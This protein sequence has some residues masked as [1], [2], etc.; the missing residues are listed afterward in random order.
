MPLTSRVA[1]VTV[2]ERIARYSPPRRSISNAHHGVPAS[3][4]CSLK[5]RLPSSEPSGENHRPMASARGKAHKSAM[6]PYGERSGHPISVSASNGRGDAARIWFALDILCK[7]HQL[8]TLTTPLLL[9]K[10]ADSAVF[11]RAQ[12]AVEL[13]MWDSLAPP[14]SLNPR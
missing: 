3:R 4:T 7:L 12:L 8:W 1:S 14:F 2:S 6:L 9:W 11:S 13:P 5:G 10:T